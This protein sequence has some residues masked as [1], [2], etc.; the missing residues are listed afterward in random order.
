M[1]REVSWPMWAMF[2]TATY[3]LAGWSA[4][5]C[6]T[7][8]DD[9]LSALFM[10]SSGVHFVIWGNFL[11]VHYCL[12]VWAIIRVLF[13]QLT[14]IE[15]D[16][17]FERLHVV[18]VTLAS[19]VITMRKTYMA[20]HMTILF[21]T[22]CLVAHWVLRDRMDFVFQVHG[23][24][25]SL[26]GI[27]CSRFMFSLLVLGMVDY[28][29]L[30]FC[31]QNT[32]VDGKRHDLYLMLA[33]SFAQLILDVLHVV[34]LTSLNLF[35]MVRSRRTRSANL[36]YEGGTTDDD[37]DDEVF[38][39]E[40]KYIYE[41]VFDLT[42]TVLKV[43]LDIIQEVFVP[44]SITVVYSIFVRSIKA[45]ESFLL[46]YN[47]W[48]NNK[49]LYEKLS[50]VSEEQLDDTDSMC[51]I[52]MDDMLPTTETTKMN[53][54]AKML[55]C[56]HM[57]HFGCLKSWMERSQTCPICR[58]S[59]FANDSNS[60]ATTQAREQTP[61]DLL[62]ERGIDEH[63]DVIGM[64]DMSVQS[65]SLHEG[66]AVRRGTTGNCM[67]QAYDGGLLSHEER[68]Q[69]G[70]VAFPIEFRADNK[71]FFNLNDSQGDRQ[72]MAS[73]TSYPRQNM[74]NSDDPDN[75]SES[76]SRIPSPSLPGSLE[77]TSSQVDVTVSAKDAPANACFV[78]ATSKLEQTK[79]VEHLKRKVEELES[80]VEE[81]SKRIKTDQV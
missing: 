53:R 58:L 40:G 2:I 37:A 33:L 6:A 63:I 23:T 52:C 19:I 15:Y 14:A 69:A 43:I 70:W 4:Y 79:E 18:L 9:P 81:L 57:L 49:K 22:L 26:L 25:S 27:L 39:L 59:V 56:G 8:F 21:Y 7:S 1:P 61:P 51:I 74:V 62:Q 31:V 10:A 16:H 36:V 11:I 60:H 80:R 48:K 38:I 64:Q 72:W 78:I 41:T 55:P 3:A 77:G 50:D 29:M 35:E 67:N 32:N 42:I 54:R 66:T 73:Y 12:F 13:G 71:V 24:D 75:A 45:G 44:W 68:D 28:K 46:V 47:Y 34:L 5:S 30:K 20:G 76:H 17:I 65:I